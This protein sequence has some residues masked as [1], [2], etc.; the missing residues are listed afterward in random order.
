[1]TKFSQYDGIED[2]LTDTIGLFAQK[3]RTSPTK[4][5]AYSELRAQLEKAIIA[6]KYLFF[7]A[8]VTIYGTWT[9]GESKL[10]YVP[11]SRRGALSIFRDKTIRIVCVGSGRFTRQ[12]AAAPVKLDPQTYLKVLKQFELRQAELAQGTTT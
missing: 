3:I 12:L 8:N 11:K 2:K 10:F 4:N 6:K 9:I 1:M 7:V 5:L